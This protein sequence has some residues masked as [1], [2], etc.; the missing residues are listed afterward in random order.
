MGGGGRWHGIDLA[1]ERRIIKKWDIN[2]LHVI[3]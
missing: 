3:L 1:K 2:V